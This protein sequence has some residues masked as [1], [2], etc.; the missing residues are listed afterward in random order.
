MPFG[1]TNTP[2]TF[3]ATMNH[4]LREHLRI[5]I[6]V[7]FNDIIIY[8]KPWEENLKHMDMVLS[9]LEEQQFYTK[10]IKCEFGMKEILFL[11][12][13]ISH[14]GVDVDPK[15][16]VVIQQWTIPTTLTYLKV[17][18]GLCSYYRGFIKGFSN[19]ST[20][21]T[22]LNKKGAFTWCEEA[23]RAFKILKKVLSSFPTLAMPNFSLL[24]MVE[25]D[26]LQ[27]V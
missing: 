12:H 9:I 6:L 19:L 22:E 21:F 8:R 13:I 18:L 4:I 10:K 23:Q 2:T 11:R 7:L 27:L 24:F 20:L 1:L 16:N 26:A 25:C 17:F 5:F 14:N 3:Q 15:K